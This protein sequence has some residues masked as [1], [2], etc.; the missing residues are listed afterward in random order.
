VRLRFTI[1]AKPGE[2]S[3][4]TSAGSPGI[5]RVVEVPFASGEATIGRGRGATI[6]LPFP[7][8]S[9]LHARLFRDESGYH[10]ED[11]GSANGT[12]LGRRRFVPHVVE[13]IAVGEVV[14]LAGIELRFD[15]ELSDDGPSSA[16]EGPATL[17][18]RLVHDIFAA[19]SPAEVAR[20]VVVAGPGLGRELALA[21]CGRVFKLGRGEQCDLVIPDD[22]VSREHATFERGDEGIVVRDLGSKNGIEVAG[23]MVVDT[24]ILR[25]G[26]VVRVGETRVRV[27][28][29]EERYLR[30]MEAGDAGLQSPGEVCNLSFGDAPPAG[31]GAAVSVPEPA[32][33]HFDASPAR[34][35]E[36]A[37]QTVCPRSRLPRVAAAIAV[38]ALLLA[39]GLVLALAFA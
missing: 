10:I 37:A 20:L 23:Q 26:E 35:S 7:T 9:S 3:V 1:R 36:V 15:G 19:C 34:T 5:E 14:D 39:L 17:A 18:R 38:T 28:D 33:A 22:D 16:G 13:A 25:D 4:V 29:P 6:E 30:Q 11:L 21:A 8:I 2:A 12:S 24:R 31:Q 32:L 27:V